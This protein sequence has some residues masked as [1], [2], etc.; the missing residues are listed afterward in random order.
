M[1][2]KIITG[3]LVILFVPTAAAFSQRGP[4]E[5]ERARIRARTGISQ[6]QQNQIEAIYRDQRRQEDEIRRKT[7]E[8]YKQLGEVYDKYDFDRNQA[9]SFRKEIGR[10]HR[11]RLH[12]HAETQDK[13]RRVMTREQFEKLNQLV[14]EQMESMRKAWEKRGDRRGPPRPP[15]L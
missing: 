3:L 4:S 15:G 13:L 10:L 5:E 2:A 12:V 7:F 8:V 9:A 6:E 11:Q 1:S 14:K